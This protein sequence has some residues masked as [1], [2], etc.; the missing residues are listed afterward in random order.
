MSQAL[1]LEA[2][3][4]LRAWSPRAKTWLAILLT[5]C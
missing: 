3:E 2:F 5:K 1:P 4:G